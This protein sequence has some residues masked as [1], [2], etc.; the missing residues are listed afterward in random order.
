MG[1][2]YDLYLRIAR[3]GPLVR[4]TFCTLEYRKHGS[5]TSQAQEQMLKGTMQILDHLEPAL[6][7]SERKKLIHARRRWK[8]EFRP[9]STFTYRLWDLYYSFRTMWNVPFRYYFGDKS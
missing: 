7:P 3:Q 1:E 9:N 5:N 6:S 8:H 2:D 4:H